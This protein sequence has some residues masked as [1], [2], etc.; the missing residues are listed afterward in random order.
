MIRPRVDRRARSQAT[1]AALDVLCTPQIEEVFARFRQ[2]TEELVGVAQ[3]ASLDL[4]LDVLDYLD[5]VRSAFKGGTD[6]SR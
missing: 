5:Q 2:A 3:L 1:T 6:A 4:R